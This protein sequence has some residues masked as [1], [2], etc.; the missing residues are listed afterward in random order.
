MCVP[1][2]H[3]VAVP[4]I[5][6]ALLYQEGWDRGH[7]EESSKDD[8]Y[9]VCMSEDID[10]LKINKNC[11]NRACRSGKGRDI[12]PLYPTELKKSRCMY[13]TSCWNCLDAHYTEQWVIRAYMHW[14][15]IG[16]PV[17][18]ESFRTKHRACGGACA[19]LASSQDHLYGFFPISFCIT[20][21]RSCCTLIWKL[22]RCFLCLC[23]GVFTN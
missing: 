3:A 17:T 22:P 18:T 4:L 9:L 5:L 10:S 16:K 21:Q 20:Y 8:S 19:P 11:R 7:D 23:L 15:V 14:R 13:V 6:Q 1:P 2:P 12:S